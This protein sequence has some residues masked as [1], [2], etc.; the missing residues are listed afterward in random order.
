MGLSM[1]RSGCRDIL[2]KIAKRLVTAHD[3]QRAHPARELAPDDLASRDDRGRDLA[4]HD[5]D[6]TDRA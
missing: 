3:A 2:R 4:G 5:V 1:H 6:L